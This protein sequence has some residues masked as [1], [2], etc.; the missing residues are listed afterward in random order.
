VQQLDEA[1]LLPPPVERYSVYIANEF[2]LVLC[3]RT[4]L[5]LHASYRTRH[6][7]PVLG[8]SPYSPNVLEQLAK[9]LV[10]ES[11]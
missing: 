2:Y 3:N 4:D 8:T 6:D 7:S 5:A 9:R 10:H 1:R 11:S